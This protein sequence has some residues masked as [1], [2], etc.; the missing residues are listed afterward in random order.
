MTPMFHQMF[1]FTKGLESPECL[2]FLMN[3][4]KDIVFK[5]NDIYEMNQ[6]T[7]DNQVKGEYQLIDLPKSIEICNKTLDKLER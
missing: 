5:I 6:V 2:H 3:S 1:F 7:Q 4:M